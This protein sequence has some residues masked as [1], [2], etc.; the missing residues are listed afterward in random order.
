M[1]PENEEFKR[2]DVP[3]F[4]VDEN[5][6]MIPNPEYADATYELEWIGHNGPID[7]HEPKLRFK[8]IEDYNKHFTFLTKEKIK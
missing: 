1:R 8:S 3:P 6:N 4:I 5:K 2:Y 7:F